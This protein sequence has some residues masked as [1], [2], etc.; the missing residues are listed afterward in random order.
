V[1]ALDADEATATDVALRAVEA[2]G[3]ALRMLGPAGGTTA[4]TAGVAEWEAG[5]SPTTLIGRADRALLHG[6]HEGGRGTAVPASSLPAAAAGGA[7]SGG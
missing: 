3:R 6:K 2:I 4:A 1:I 5:D 7:G